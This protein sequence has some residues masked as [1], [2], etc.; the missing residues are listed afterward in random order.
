M[1]VLGIPKMTQMY[2]K[3]QYEIEEAD[4]T[5]RKK[6]EHE[7]QFTIISLFS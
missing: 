6:Y 2:I 4:E 7:S 1:F 3:R 5:E